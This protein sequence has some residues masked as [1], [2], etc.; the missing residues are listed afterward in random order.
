LNLS[1]LVEHEALV[2]QLYKHCIS[3]YGGAD[4]VSYSF[5]VT[6][7]GAQ[8]RPPMVGM[9][10][11]DLYGKRPQD[12]FEIIG[13][14]KTKGD[15]ENIH[16]EKQIFDYTT[17]VQRSN[18]VLAFIVPWPLQIACKALILR[19]NPTFKLMKRKLIIVPGGSI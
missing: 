13:E 6:G 4:Q 5:D 11:P 14:A 3:K 7:S 15:L 12:G 18:A 9:S 19:V 1:I 10:R 16:T 8:S 2:Q 17:Y